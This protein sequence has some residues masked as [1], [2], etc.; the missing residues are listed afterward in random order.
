MHKD[1]PEKSAREYILSNYNVD[2]LYLSLWTQIFHIK[3]LF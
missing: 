2:D 3:P 1:I